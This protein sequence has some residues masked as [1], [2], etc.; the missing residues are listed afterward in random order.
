MKKRGLLLLILLMLPS[1]L[2][3]IPSSRLPPDGWH[4]IVWENPFSQWQ[5][6]DVTSRGILPNTG[7]VTAALQSLIDSLSEPT[8]LYFPKG[9]YIVNDLY[10]D[11][12]DDN[13]ILKGLGRDTIFETTTGTNT[14][15]LYGTPVGPQ[16]S[17]IEDVPP[18]GKIIY[19]SDVS[20]LAVGD[21]V[22]IVEDLDYYG[23]EWGKR[24]RGGV[25]KVT[26]VDTIAKTVTLDM[27]L[28]IGIDQVSS[29]NAVL[30]EFD[31]L[32]NIGIRDIT[33]V[34]KSTADGSTLEFRW[35]SNGF[36]Q[37]ISTFNASESHVE[38]K[39]SR[40]IVVKDSFFSGAKDMS[41]GHGYGVTSEHRS[42]GILITN[43]IM[44]N[45]HVSFGIQLGSSYN[46]YSYNYYIDELKDICNNEKPLDC[47]DR[48]W[49]L[50]KDLNGLF[51]SRETVGFV[52]HGH[53]PHNN[54]VEGNVEYAICVDHI[55][56]DNGPH[57]TFF[58]NKLLGQPDF[59]PAY[60]LGGTGFHI[61]GP[62]DSQN[63]IG[64]VFMNNA[65][66]EIGTWSYDPPRAALDTFIAKNIVSGVRN[67]S[68]IN[69]E[70]TRTALYHW[71]NMTEDETIP[72]SLYLSSKPDFWP[73]D[74]EWPPFG[75]D[76]ANSATNKI[77]AELRYAQMQQ[78]I[79]M[80]T[81]ELNQ[82][83]Y[84]WLQGSLQTNNLIQ[85][86]GK[87][88]RGFTTITY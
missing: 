71:D 84:S 29:K 86:I 50:D 9:K 80:T 14:I 7:D 40:Q 83:I 85:E 88:K 23:A 64:N 11:H 69:G 15:K 44:K 60:W 49:I 31:P 2:A 62:S 52:F 68:N 19:L 73:P 33:I 17:I 77:P 1:V 70:F 32:E 43:N 76:V 38:I 26:A 3:V 46:I 12:Q 34:R 75:P 81:E 10:M 79:P 35:V 55:W 16:I 42:T 66:I 39:E 21:A 28:A 5:T 8:I 59:H 27:P 24:G 13:I 58:R 37:N 18:Y 53:Y 63:I 72:Y 41:G 61:D 20:S 65:F 36:V 87:W 56:K 45:L 57:N 30:Q 22:S 25:F 82:K 6:I 4:E 67:F 51:D 74:L 47:N 54:L 78:A 48:N